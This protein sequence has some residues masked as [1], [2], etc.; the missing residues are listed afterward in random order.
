[1][2][3]RWV[4]SAAVCAALGVV[5][6]GCS[7]EAGVPKPTRLD[8]T[9]AGLQQTSDL[10]A[11]IGK[12][13]PGQCADA[14]PNDF[15]QFPVSMKQF[16]SDVVPTGQVLCEVNGELVEI[17]VFASSRDRDRYL[18]D[19]STGICTQAKRVAKKANQPL[20][21]SGLRWVVGDG[22][23]TVQPDSESLARKLSSVT[24]GKYVPRQCATGITIDWDRDA[25]AAMGDVHRK[26]TVGG[27]PCGALEMVGRETLQKTRRLTNDQLPAALGSCIVAGSTIEIITYRERNQAVDTFIADRA[28]QACA[29]DSALGRID[30]ALFTLL[31][32]GTVAE[33]LVQ[34][35]AGTLAQTTCDD[36]TANTTSSTSVP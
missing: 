19:R 17:S 29:G 1:M 10:A 31:V 24:N 36:P 5:V 33:D 12:A 4:A 2:V 20:L 6:A 26:I 16:K 23:V 27:K 28:R 7:S 14:V 18:E 9:K 21:F 32:P 15:A 30:G 8:W 11:S 34:A 25:T 13:L 35:V 3:H 22:N